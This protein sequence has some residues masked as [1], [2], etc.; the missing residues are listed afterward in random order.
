MTRAETLVTFFNNRGLP[1]DPLE[2]DKLPIFALCR[3]LITRLF[4][5][6]IAAIGDYVKSAFSGFSRPQSLSPSRYVFTY[7]ARALRTR[8]NR[9]SNGAWKMAI[10]TRSSRPRRVDI[11]ATDDENASGEPSS[12][13]WRSTR[14]S[15]T[16]PYDTVRGRVGERA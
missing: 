5:K 9:K 2:P 3:Y 10:A 1:I 16:Y 15:S 13:C 7:C 4:K 6:V 12:S 14:G 8:A 11:R